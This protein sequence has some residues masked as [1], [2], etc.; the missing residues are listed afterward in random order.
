MGNKR[1][2]T[3]P[4]IRKSSDGTILWHVNAAAYRTYTNCTAPY[5]Q[6]RTAQ[7]QDQSVPAMR[8]KRDGGGKNR[9]VVTTKNWER[10]TRN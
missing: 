5:V 8:V 3:Q 6:N 1:R 10:L 7:H 4:E 2:K 9:I